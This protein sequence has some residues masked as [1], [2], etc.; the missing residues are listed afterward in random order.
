M[1]RSILVIDDD[2]DDCRI[3][4]ESLFQAGFRDPVYSTLESSEAFKLLEQ[5]KGNF[6]TLIILDLNMP[7]VSGMEI[8]KLIVKGYG[9]PVIMYTTSCDDE[10]VKEAKS[11]GAVDCI[12]KGT[13]YSDNL[14]F[15]KYVSDLLRNYRF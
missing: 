9:I 2:E 10:T 4:K 13:S 15:A 14:K 5:M 6:P 8:L 3:I 7:L 1:Q 12:Q 11:L